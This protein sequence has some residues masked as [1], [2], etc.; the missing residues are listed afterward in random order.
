M[1]ELRNEVLPLF[2]AASSSK[3]LREV[4]WLIGQSHGHLLSPPRC[5]SIAFSTIIQIWVL[6]PDLFSLLLVFS[7]GW[8]RVYSLRVYL[9]RSFSFW[10]ISYTV[11]QNGQAGWCLFHI[12]RGT[13]NAQRNLKS[14][15]SILSRV[16]N[17]KIMF[18]FEFQDSSAA[19]N[20]MQHCQ[21]QD[22]DK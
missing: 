22:S 8:S 13:R 18:G 7:I 2:L 9:I 14:V 19:R 17:Y 11:C 10:S 20:F 16:Q 21:N 3:L 5:I 15:P 12:G 4:V 1:M 6:K